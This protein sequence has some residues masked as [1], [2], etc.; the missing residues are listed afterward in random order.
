[1]VMARRIGSPVPMEIHLGEPEPDTLRGIGGSKSDRF[2]AALI[3]SVVKTGWFPTGMS[4][5]DRA[6]QIFVAVT[7][8]EAFRP[9]DE[10]EAMLCAQAMAA[11][12]ASM[13]CARRAMFPDQPF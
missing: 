9:K 11:H 7:G 1:M 10:V 2:N 3:D 5:E 6:K 12:H 8:L 4:D 13:E